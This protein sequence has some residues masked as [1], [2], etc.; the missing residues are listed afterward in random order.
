MGIEGKPFPGVSFV[1]IGCRDLDAIREF[2]RF[3]FGWQSLE[4]YKSIAMYSMSGFMLAFYPDQELANDIGIPRDN[5]LRLNGSAY[6]GFAL[7]V[8]LKSR[9]EVDA[10]FNRLRRLNVAIMKEPEE[11][12]WGGYRGYIMDIENNPWEI[13]FNPHLY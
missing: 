2:Y 11:V 3:A 9:N 4:K 10:E 5:Q 1:T 12:F 13:V 8:N 7:A 6:K